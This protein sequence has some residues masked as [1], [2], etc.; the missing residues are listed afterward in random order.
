[1]TGGQEAW[2]AFEKQLAKLYDD[3]FLDLDAEISVI[4]KSMKMEGVG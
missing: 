1:M 2:K 4:K 3:D